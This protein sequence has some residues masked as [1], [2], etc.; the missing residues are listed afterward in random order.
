MRQKH[1]EA[2]F[3][4]LT[5]AVY[6]DSHISLKEEALLESAFIAEGWESEFPKSLFIE[7][8]FARARAAIESDEE[9]ARYLAE[10]VAV[11]TDKGSQTE[12][13]GVVKSILE[14]D[15]LSTGDSKF[16]TQ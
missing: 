7:Q 4:L 1:R 11:F 13:C 9:T 14:R 3:D 15:G 5:L 8:S 12:A 16:Y 6:A 10:R 2:L